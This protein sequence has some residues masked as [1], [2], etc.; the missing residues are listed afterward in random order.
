MGVKAQDIIDIMRG[1]IG[2]DKRQIIDLYNS[3]KPLA[4]GYA[5]QY[6]DAWCDTTVSA[7]F[8]KAGAV[9]LIGGTE[10]G[11]ERHIQL[12]KKAGIWEED[13]TVTPTP[14]AV[15]CYNWDDGTQ[16]NDGWADHIGIV[17]SVFGTTIKLI[18]GNLNDKVDRREIPVGWG[19]IRGYAFPKYD[20]ADAPAPKAV[21]AGAVDIT[22]P[23]IDVSEWQGVIDWEQVKPQIGGA[24]IRVAYGA[25]RVDKYV[26][27]NLSE[28]DRLGIP[29]GVYLYSL[30][31][32]EVTAWAEADKALALIKGHKL[33]MPVYVDIEENQY[34]G[35]ARVVAKAFCDV[36]EAA[37]YK[38]GVYASE[39][40]FNSYIS[41]VDIPGCSYWIARYGT[42]DGR[43]QTKPNVQ[44]QID[45]W[46]YTSVGRFLGISGN[47]DTN[48]FYNTFA[49]EDKK[50]TPAPVDT[51]HIY[52]QTYEWTGEKK[53]S[54][55]IGTR[56]E[57]KP[58]HALRINPPEGMEL[59]VTVHVQ[60]YGDLKYS[61]LTHGNDAIIGGVDKVKRIEGICIKV[62]KNTTGKKLRYQ[63]HVQGTGDTKWYNSGEYCGTRGQSKRL[64]AIRME[65]VS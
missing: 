26:D 1:W 51:P 58:L 53:E 59:E 36:I 16:P 41:G 27:R 35:A 30:A 65:L 3:H 32:N 20:K 46:Q 55:W 52:G 28:C 25:N 39:S 23:V 13:G 9:D 42:N 17:E 45:G 47:V 2:V 19:Y 63:G 12:F 61:G 38:Y 44:V 60:S 64:E 14:G 29:Y 57:S 5:V 62:T 31:Y 24:I 54:E 21:T 33:T 18:E 56:G 50:P 11:V 37:G 7:A 15:I 49:G 10:C 40:Y 43:K 8:I 6:N 22:K 4:Q 48:E 34:R